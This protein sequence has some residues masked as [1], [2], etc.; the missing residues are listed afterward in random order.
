MD[1]LLEFFL[2]YAVRKWKLNPLK[3]GI[4]LIHI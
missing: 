4:E 1:Y 2:L 3:F